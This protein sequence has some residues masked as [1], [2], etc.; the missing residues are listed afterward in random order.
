[1]YFFFFFYVSYVVVLRKNT[2]LVF[3]F[4][5]LRWDKFKKKIIIEVDKLGQNDT[6]LL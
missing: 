3:F 1:M 4:K 5:L 6:I 2:I